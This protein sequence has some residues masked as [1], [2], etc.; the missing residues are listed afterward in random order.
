[1]RLILVVISTILL[2]AFISCQEDFDQT[3]LNNGK[4][5]FSKDTVYLDTVFS[6]IGSSTRTLKIY[7]TSKNNITI[8]TIKLGRGEASFY[9]LNVDGLSGKAIPK[10]EYS[11]KR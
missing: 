2:F 7:N 9:R 3:V 5:T 10:H 1:M 11:C 6:K 4:L 8:P